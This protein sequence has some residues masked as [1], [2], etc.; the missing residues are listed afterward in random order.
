M[1]SSKGLREELERIRRVSDMLCT[2]HANLRDHYAGMAF[3]LDLAILALTTWLAA[4]AFVAPTI[5]VSL[6]PFGMD[7]QV[8]VGLLS[9]GALFLAIVQLKTDWKAR[10]EAHRRTLDIYSEVKREAGYLLAADEVDE[11]TCRRVLARYDTASAAGVE[12]PE[13]LF[14][15]QKRRHMMKVAVSKH[16]DAHPGASIV[17]TRV[18]FW[19]R[20]NFG[21]D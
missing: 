19:F 16:L 8:W 6:T 14:L 17:L 2:G 3:A 21:R 9:V 15:G 5:N 1:N 10:S 20:D 18:R 11:E 12:I 7:V 13:R 4:L